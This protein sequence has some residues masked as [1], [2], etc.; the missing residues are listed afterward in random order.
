[1]TTKQK[2]HIP[3]ALSAA[4]DCP[5]GY[6]LQADAETIVR[7][8]LDRHH[9][10]RAA[11]VELGFSDATFSELLK[12]HPALLSVPAQPTP[13]AVRTPR[14]LSTQAKPKRLQP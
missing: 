3:R 1:M 5:E 2:N 8:A 10:R 12:R 4:L 7:A 9:T 13:A 14:Q 6:P 11:A